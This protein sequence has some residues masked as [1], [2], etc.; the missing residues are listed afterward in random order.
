MIVKQ[1]RYYDER[2]KQFLN[3]PD[4]ITAEKLASGEYFSSIY[5]DEI[6]IKTY[7]GTILKINDE[8]IHI[9]E[10]GVYNILYR[11][12]VSI[13]SLKV[14]EKSI[15]FIRDS[16]KAYFVITFIQHENNSESNN[17]SGTGSASSSES[18]TDSAPSSDEDS[19]ASST[20]KIIDN[21]DN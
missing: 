14:L 3:S 13:Y 5:C 1:I 9:G 16:D 6:Q 18:Q 20:N 12:G 19:S 4:G 7:P 17:N 11:E 10:T 2:D 21:H 8:E 15:N